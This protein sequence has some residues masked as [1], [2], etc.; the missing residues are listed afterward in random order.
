MVHINQSVAFALILIL[1][2][3][4]FVCHQNK[5]RP[6]FILLIATTERLAHKL[7]NSILHAA[8]DPSRN[9]QEGFVSSGPVYS[10]SKEENSIKISR[11]TSWWVKTAWTLD[12]YSFSLVKLPQETCRCRNWRRRRRA[13]P[14]SLKCNQPWGSSLV[15][16]LF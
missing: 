13:W 14:S 6:H 4:Y 8:T 9:L 16:H 1:G 5:T 11:W 15:P 3:R 7:Y 12:P 2:I 10:S